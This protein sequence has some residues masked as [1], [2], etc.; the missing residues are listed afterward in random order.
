[1][2]GIS[3]RFPEANNTDAFWNNLPKN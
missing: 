2:V 1:M 3:C